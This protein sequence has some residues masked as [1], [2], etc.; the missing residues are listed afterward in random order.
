MNEFLLQSV[1]PVL[2]NPLSKKVRGLIDSLRAQRTRYMKVTQMVCVLQ[3]WGWILNPGPSVCQTSTLITELHAQH[4]NCALNPGFFIL[5][6]QQ[7]GAWGGSVCV[8]RYHLPSLT[9]CLLA[10]AYR[11][12]TGRQAG[13]DVQALPGG[14]QEPKWR[15]ILCGLSLSYAQGD[16][17]A[18]ELKQVGKWHRS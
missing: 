2:D 1:L 3:W 4:S 10:V 18:T 14:R 11:G 7:E 13:D 16:T 6:S 12:Q 5:S 8:L 9:I 17:A 15:C